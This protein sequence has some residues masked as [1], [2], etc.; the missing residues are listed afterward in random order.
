MA[1]SGGN[2][3]VLLAG[4]TKQRA[5]QG[6]SI[7]PLLFGA[8]IGA[9]FTQAFQ[10]L[11]LQRRWGGSDR[12]SEVP[13]EDSHATLGTVE[14]SSG[15]AG[16]VDAGDMVGTG[17]TGGKVGLDEVMPHSNTVRGRNGVLCPECEAA[18]AST[19]ADAAALTVQ[20]KDCMKNNREILEQ[21]DL[22]SSDDRG[23]A[24]EGGDV[25]AAK[26]EDNG[27]ER[28]EIEVFVGIQSGYS[29][30]AESGDDYNYQDRRAVIRET[31]FRSS[32][33]VFMDQLDEAGIVVKFV[34]GQGPSKVSQTMIEL[35]DQEHKDIM[36]LDVKEDYR[37]LVTKSR[38]FFKKVMAAYSP[39]YIVKVDD[40]VYL[41]LPRLSAAV[42]Q[43]ESMRVDYTGCMKRGDVQK[44]QAYKWFEPQHQLLGGEYFSHAWGSL[45]VL[46]GRAAD[47]MSSVSPSLLREFENEDVT[48]GLFML[49][50]D[51][52]YYDDRRLC[53]ASCQGGGIGLYDMPWPGLK[54]V[55]SRMKE[56]RSSP[57]CQADRSFNVEVPMVPPLFDF[58]LHDR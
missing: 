55:I 12:S 52:Q 43:W 57:A 3:R 18:L 39:K 10:P 45:Y 38:E 8:L 16:A 44:N 50:T 31:W 30:N 15:L 7:K 14:G 49:A 47:A 23:D 19:A 20:L 56:L 34:I 26:D 33:R 42:K 46:S 29:P 1:N 4:T 54:G 17:G 13:F 27:V 22:G 11:F 2:G 48:I 21:L 40:D 25:R 35:E 9:L 53:K 37:N 32:D 28:K 5:Q 58:R 51:M 6:S 24:G 36:M 41:Q